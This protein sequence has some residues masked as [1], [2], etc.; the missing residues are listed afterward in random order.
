MPILIDEHQAG[1]IE[2]DSEWAALRGPARPLTSP[3][4]ANIGPQEPLSGEHLTTVLRTIAT[5][6]T[7]RRTRTPTNV[8]RVL[9]AAFM[10]GLSP[11]DVPEALWTGDLARSRA[12][13][14]AM[15]FVP[16][17]NSSTPISRRLRDIAMH[18][19]SSSDRE[20]TR[21]ALMQLVDEL[22]RTR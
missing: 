10:A 4:L 19:Q 6:I 3:A 18:V 12:R 14:L 5:E 2:V 13:A 22:R 7:S 9:G 20:R 8:T 16:T 11:L 15:N 17:R 21:D 1:D